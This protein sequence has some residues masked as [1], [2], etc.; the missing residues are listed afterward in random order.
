MRS[1]KWL[2]IGGAAFCLVAVASILNADRL[3]YM[4][5]ILLTLPGVSYLLGWYTLR[6]LECRRELPRAAWEGEEGTIVYAITNHARVARFFLRVHEPLPAWIAPLES[7]PPLF[8]VGAKDTTRIVHRVSFRKRGVYYAGA[9]DITAIDPLGV[10]SFTQRV[11]GDDEL[12]VYPSPHRIQGLSLSGSERYGWQEFSSTVLR[13]SSVDPDGVRKYAPGDP[14]RRIHWR[15]TART[16]TLSVIEFEESQSINMVIAL[17]LLRGTEVGEGSETTLEYAV[18]VAASVAQQAIQQG[19][20]VRLLVPP[21]QWA[22]QRHAVSLEVVATARRGQEQLFLILDALARVQAE[23]AQPVST[24]VEETVG[25]LP[26]GTTLLVL[27]ARPDGALPGV[28]T[29][30][31]ATGTNVVVLYIDPESFQ[32]GHNRVSSAQ[33][34]QFYAELVAVRAQPFILRGGRQGDLYPEAVVDTYVR[35]TQPTAT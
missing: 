34:R 10:V 7:E 30:Y 15:Q 21:D 28:L 22:G 18:R 27:T 16:G 29:R 20:S 6:G 19:A 4:A 32:G 33:S 24:L 11:P 9:F 35:S 26:P 8:N 23:S 2:T 25:N 1:F 14:L 5:A 3:Y 13:G 12:V 17:D 31:T